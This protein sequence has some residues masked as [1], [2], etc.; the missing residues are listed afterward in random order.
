MNQVEAKKEGWIT[1]YLKK[2]SNI[3]F[4]IIIVGVT[5]LII[6]TQVDP[7][8]FLNIIK[9]TKIGFLLL[10]IGCIFIY[11]LLEAFMLL[12]L[13]NRAKANEDFSFAFALTMVGQYYNLLDPSSSGGQPL[14]LYEMSKKGY[15]LGAGT[16]VLVKK[17]ALYQVTITFLAIIATVFNITELHRSLDAAKW[18]IGIGL[19]LNIAAVV[20]IF[21]LIYSPRVA[22]KI[23]LSCGNLL[24]KLHIL[25][26]KEKYYKKVDHFV[27]EYKIAIKSL[28]SNKWKTFQLFLISIVQMIFFYSVNYGFICHWGYMIRMPLPLFRFKLFS[29]LQWPLYRHPVRREGLKQGFY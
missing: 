28:T 19:I 12:K 9:Q 11:W 4:F 15:S 27:G 17:Y 13:L 23:I 14:Q 24:L 25:R 6:L 22:K 20:L 21:I 2:Y 1:K 26:D 29:M 3:I 8:T 10:G 16:A 18:L 7:I 5:A